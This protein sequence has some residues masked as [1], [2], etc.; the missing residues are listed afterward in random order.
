[1]IDGRTC[2]AARG[3]LAWTARYLSTRSGVPI[4]RIFEFERDRPIG[5]D[6]RQSLEA[7]FLRHGVMVTGDG[8]RAN[9]V[10]AIELPAKAGELASGARLAGTGG[11]LDSLPEP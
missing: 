7:T 5:E 3:F 10:R 8:R 6:D 2:R 11:D 9:G 4:S 1:L